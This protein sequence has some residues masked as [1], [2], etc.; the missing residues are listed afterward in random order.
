MHGKERRFQGQN[1]IKVAQLRVA[2]LY[3]ILKQTLH[4]HLPIMSVSVSD[5]P[6]QPLTRASI[7][8]AAFA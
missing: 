2:S 5:P 8:R 4:A 3:K 1:G 6:S 7:P